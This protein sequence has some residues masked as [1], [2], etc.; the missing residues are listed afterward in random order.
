VKVFSRDALPVDGFVR[1]FVG[2]ENSG[3]PA[4]VIFVDAQPGDRVRLHRHPYHE[5][6]LVLEGEATFEDGETTVVAG[7]GQMVVVPP[8]EPHAFANRG[9]QP[10]RQIDVHLNEVFVTEWLE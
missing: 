5:L 1:E 9:T 10:L 7:A 8:H 3:V 6:F 2:G 4:C